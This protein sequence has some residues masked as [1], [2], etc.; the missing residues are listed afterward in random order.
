MLSVH[1]RN[2]SER[3]V[4]GCAITGMSVYLNDVC[5][6]RILPGRMQLLIYMC[7]YIRKGNG[8]LS[9]HTAGDTLRLC[10]FSHVFNGQ[11]HDH[12]AI[13]IQ[14]ISHQLMVKNYLILL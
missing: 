1:R 13:Y 5:V 3:G 7:S 12:K 9:V 2:V 14:Q 11:I 10:W 4:T 8:L 6:C